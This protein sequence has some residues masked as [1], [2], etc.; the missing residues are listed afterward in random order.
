LEGILSDE[1]DSAGLFYVAPVDLDE[2]DVS[3]N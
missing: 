2:R 3:A 1:P